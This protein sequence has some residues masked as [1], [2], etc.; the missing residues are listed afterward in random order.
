LLEEKVGTV[1]FV[2]AVVFMLSW[3]IALSAYG[4]IT[5]VLITAMVG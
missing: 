5:L 1:E 4:V 3:P 2:K